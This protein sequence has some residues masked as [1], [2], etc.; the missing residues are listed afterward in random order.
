MTALYGVVLCNGQ[1]PF[2]PGSGWRD[3]VC[4]NGFAQGLCAGF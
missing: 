1:A 2:R 4:V 3:L